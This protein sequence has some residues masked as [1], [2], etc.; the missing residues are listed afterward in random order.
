MTSAAIYARVS[1]ARQKKDETI[2]SQT[3]ALRAHAEQLGLEVTDEW[4]FEDEGH[5][6]ATLVRPALE[7][8]RDLIAGVGIDVVLCYSPDRLARKFAYRA[9]LIEEFTR[10]GTR[11]RFIK[12]PRGDSPEDQ[13]LVQFQ[14]MFAEYE[15][16]Q[17]LK[18]YRRGK[19]HRAQTGSIS[20]LGGAPFGYRYVRKNEHAGAGYEIIEH[21]AALVAELFRRYADDGASIAELTRWLT[22]QGV[23]TRTSKHRWDRG[24]VWGMLR[25]PAYAGRAVFGKTR[26]VH[27]SPGLN[28]VARLQ[29]RSTPKASKT[30]DRPGPAMRESRSRCRPSSART[31]SSASPSGWPTTSASPPASRKDHQKFVGAFRLRQLRLPSGSLPL[32]SLRS[33][34]IK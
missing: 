16:A 24:V 11:V 28:R 14:G 5:S 30:V 19:T 22:D 3:A 9:L 2:G 1:S 29:G 25:N 13:P 15:K 26:V 8:L 32:L 34:C 31:P 12:G 27:E 20:V 4:V 17:I 21:E 7:R 10:A 18:R 33:L 6:G 23:P